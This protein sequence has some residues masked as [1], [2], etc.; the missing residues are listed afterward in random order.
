M[1]F[2]GFLLFLS[3]WA[4]NCLLTAK[5][6]MSFRELD[7]WYEVFMAGSKVG[8]SH[9]TMK[10]EKD[11][12]VSKSISTISVNRAGTTIEIKSVETT[13]ETI[14]GDIIS[15]SSEI[16]MGGV[17]IMKKGYVDGDKIVVREKQYFRE[18][19]KRYPLDRNGKMTWGLMRTLR[20]NDFKIKGNVFDTKIYSADF[21]M[22]SPTLAKIKAMGKSTVMILGQP[23]N[24]FKTEILMSTNIGRV[25]SV[26]W[27]DEWGFAVQIKMQLGSLPIE[28]KQSSETKAKQRTESPELLLNT[29]ILL[30]KEIP[31]D[32]KKVLLKVEITDGKASSTLYQSEHQKVTRLEEKVF[33]VELSSEKWGANLI[34]KEKIFKVKPE[35]KNSNLM[36]DSM[37][38]LIR[39]LAQNAGNGS[40]NIIELSEKLY[41][42]TQNYLVHKNFNV[43][44]GSAS[45]TAKKR[46][47]DCTEHAVFLAALGRSMGIPSRVATGL[48]YMKN[49]KGNKNVMG[50]HMW[51]EF[52]LKGSWVR[53]DSALGKIGTH[54]DRIT[55]SVSSLE[56]NGL[57]EISFGI[58]EMINNL[59]ISVMSAG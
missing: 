18:A 48:A 50:F 33:H 17:P 3:F 56:Q 46:E 20:E 37:D 59:K 10:L 22:A 35:Y 29:L 55:L 43:G 9:S 5:D 40:K 42:F 36:I 44:F 1:R 13:R 52:H 14:L 24:T 11:E 19:R 4:G 23:M 12:V 39:Q 32:A 8:Y 58:S 54:A 49:F 30:E 47:G 45:E 51:T 7:R 34:G 6:K 31:A 21:G 16:L 15:F 38:P 53:L 26:N 2:V 25:K 28:M 57:Q 41:L 27:L